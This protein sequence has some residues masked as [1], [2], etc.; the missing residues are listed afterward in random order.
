MPLSWNEIRSRA[1]AFS[2]EWSGAES[3][4]AEK[5]SFWNAFFDV[6][7]VSRRQVASFEVPV[8]KI[9]G[10]QGAIDLFWPAILLVEHKSRGGDLGKAEAQSFGYIR[11]L[12]GEGR[13]AEVP[14]YIITS[15]FARIALHDLEPDEQ[16]DLP[17]FQGMRVQ[18]T[19]FPVSELHRHVHLFAFIAGYKQHRFEEQDPINIKAVEI[20]G[21]LHDALAGG[22]YRG[23][24]LERFL[25]RTLFCLFAED[26]GIFDRSVFTSY[27]KERTAPD[28]SDLGVRLAQLF[29]V[30]D[31]PEDDRQRSLDETL[32]AF[33]YV[34]GSLFSERLRFADF[35]RAMRDALVKCTNFDWSRIS[36][37]VF[38]SLFQSVMEP[39]ERRQIGA[40]YTSERDILKVIRPLFLDALAEEFRT[41]QADRSTRKAERL[42][43]F[44]DKLAGL[45]FLDPACGCGNFLVITYRELRLLETEL[46]KDLVPA[47]PTGHRPAELDVQS[48]TRLEVNQFYGIEIDEWPARIAEVALWLMDHQMNIRLSM[49]L[50]QQVLK[51]PLRAAPHI[52]VGNALRTEWARVL[53][54]GQCSYVLGNPP[55]VGAKY[56]ND[57][58]RADMRAVAEG[59]P[60]HGLLDYVCGWYLKAADY[61]AGT[62]IVCAFVSTNS[63]TQGEQ[64][65]V[66]WNHLFQR[67]RIK[68]HF[69]HRTFAWMS[70]ARGRAHVHVVII[71][72]AAF[73]AP[74]KTIFDYSAGGGEPT[75]IAVA[76][77]SP[78]LS[79]GPDLAI[80][81]RS[82]PVSPVP[83]LAIGNKPIDGG[84]YLFTPEERR[85]FLY[86][87]PGARRLFRRWMGAEEYINGVERWCLWL[88]DT[89]PAELRR[90]RHVMER[91]AAVR[92]SRLASRSEPT[93]RLAETPTRY[94]VENMPESRYLVIPEVSSERRRYIPIGFLRPEVVASNK[95]RIMRGATHYHFGVLTSSMHMAWTNAVTGRLKSDYQYSVKLVYNNF[96]WPVDMADDR[97]EAVEAAAQE[98]LDA[99]DRYPA[100][101]LADLYDPDTMPAD[102]LRAHRALDRAVERCYR[103]RAF[104]SDRERLEWLFALYNRITAPLAPE[105]ERPR[106]RARRG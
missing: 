39:P 80:V 58:Q 103:A 2:K 46:L 20:L 13:Q 71:G 92:E 36:P 95:L 93:R 101:T 86:R 100:C 70:E 82:E 4:R 42:R 96:P 72:F 89:P 85:E 60:S 16:K 83:E 17:L 9:G 30:L 88:G 63:I 47:D 22:G 69:A 10:G 3:E 78:Y 81:N 15:D 40:H 19:E 56:Q 31:T 25:V 37:A 28:G 14:R 67:Y 98:V 104:T 79:E 1:L 90:L 68:I 49:A 102:L 84:H 59:V 74:G 35:G 62:R 75:A 38:G 5:Q 48:L 18:S 41:V 105:P 106:R 45:R 64:V 8:K 6:F 21:D 53:A 73:D 94:H 97:R 23:H 65:G 87:E 43:A 77:V 76:N 33:P 52:H 50:G 29:E 34:N 44:Q 24:D 26:T 51:L 12:V 61:I 99:R 7:G 55:F 27:I 32:A 11:D 54:P 66:L 91:I 57:S